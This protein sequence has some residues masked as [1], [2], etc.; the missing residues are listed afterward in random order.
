MNNNVVDS[1]IASA[2]FAVLSAGLGLILKAL[3][4]SD[5]VSVITALLTLLA[6]IFLFIII[7]RLYPIYTRR[8]AE[9]TLLSTLSVIDSNDPRMAL[10]KKII[11]RVLQD[12]AETDQ[13]KRDWI[14]I[15]ENQ[16]VCEPYLQDAF[17]KAGKV[18]ILTIRGRKYFSGSR[19]L[20][21]DILEKRGRNFSVQVLVLSPWSSHIT[22][23]LAQNIGQHSAMEIKRNMLTVLEES[24]I[25]LANKNKNF[26]V[27]CYDETPNFKLLLFDDVMFVSAFIEPNND[28]NANMLRITRE[29]T[30][31][32]KGLENHFDDLWKRS[33]PPANVLDG[34]V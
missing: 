27:R 29:G 33:V 13:A 14:R 18:K 21:Y 28:R 22:D 19:S 32:F 15:Y 10:K 1:I 9:R 16:E 7:K 6:L 4:L 11:E 5:Q 30:P 34:R 20:F 25:D 26:G 17:R 24:L 8:L 31:L 23:K 3:R 2:I 12:N